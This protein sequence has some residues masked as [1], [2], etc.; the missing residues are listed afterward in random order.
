M[1]D[2]G[3]AAVEDLD[4]R[5]AVVEAEVVLHQ[6]QGFVVAE[7]AV[8]LVVLEVVQDDAVAVRRLVEVETVAHEVLRDLVAVADVTADDD[9][10]AGVLVQRHG[11]ED[12]DA[13]AVEFRHLGVVVQH[14][15]LQGAVVTA[16]HRD[17]V[18]GHIPHQ[19]VADRQV[20]GPLGADAGHVGEGG[21]S[22][23]LRPHL[24]PVDDHVVAILDGKELEL[25]VP[26]D[27][28]PP[29]VLR[30]D[31]GGVTGRPPPEVHPRFLLADVVGPVH[32]NDL[33]PAA[34]IGSV[35]APLDGTEG[36]VDATVAGVVAVGADVK[37]SGVGNG[38]AQQAQQQ[39]AERGIK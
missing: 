7:G 25:R 22:G 6:R 21:V 14:V 8:Q 35:D 39:Y 19:A 27:D 10:E 26:H 16:R 18:T 32:D 29:A 15:V 31:D 24:Q 34:S 36:L 30:P 12:R 28:G 38:R 23:V 13:R 17:P 5:A 37:G 1:A 3:V 4:A 20:V 2:H 11:L 9:V 33:V